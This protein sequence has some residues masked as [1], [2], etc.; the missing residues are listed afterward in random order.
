MVTDG[1][2]RPARAGSNILCRRERQTG[3]PGVAYRTIG[4]SLKDSFADGVSV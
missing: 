2:P 4:T 1:F 3:G